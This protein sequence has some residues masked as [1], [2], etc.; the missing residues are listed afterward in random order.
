MFNKRYCNGLPRPRRFSKCLKIPSKLILYI[1][2]PHALIRGRWTRTEML[3]RSHIKHELMTV[4]YGRNSLSGAWL[5]AVCKFCIT[6]CKTTTSLWSRHQRET[7]GRVTTSSKMFQPP[8][9]SSNSIRPEKRINQYFSCWC[10]IIK[11][12][13]VLLCDAAE[14]W[15]ICH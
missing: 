1:H 12:T 9:F 3:S 4:L 15:R 14:T 13:R 2:K 6:L 7:N 5:S 8:P 11:T 10:H